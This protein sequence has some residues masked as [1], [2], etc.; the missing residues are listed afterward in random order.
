MERSGSSPGEAAE[1]GRAGTRALYIAE[2][3]AVSLGLQPICPPTNRHT[4]C[5]LPPQ[6]PGTQGWAEMRDGRDPSWEAQES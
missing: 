4:P 3:P 1:A 6:R 5:Y 2:C